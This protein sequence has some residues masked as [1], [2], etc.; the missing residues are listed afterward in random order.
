MCFIIGVDNHGAA[1]A[2]LGSAS[3]CGFGTVKGV[4]RFLQTDE[5]TCLV[6]GTL[7]GLTPGLHGLHV[8]ECGDISQGC[9][10]YLHLQGNIHKTFQNSSMN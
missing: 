7:D 2:M 3:V 1:V 5:N 8:H 10:R 9:D 4:I 6:E